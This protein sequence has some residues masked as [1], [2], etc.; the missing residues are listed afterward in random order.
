MISSQA[1]ADVLAALWFEVDHRDGADAHLF[2]TPDAD[3][4]FGS[5][6]FEGRTAIQRVY[7]GRAAR[8]PRVSRHIMSNV[9]ITR[10]DGDTAEVMSALC[11]YAQDGIGPRPRATPVAI[12]DVR[13]RFVR[14]PTGL[15]I[16]SRTITNQFMETDAEFAVPTQ[17]QASQPPTQRKV[18]A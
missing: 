18:D 10:V 15:L 7:R 14:T 13:D 1:V 4:T 11:L 8:G 17:P 12:S 6:R 9:H 2:F 3:L 16:A 5:A